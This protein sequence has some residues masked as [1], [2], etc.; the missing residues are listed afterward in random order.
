MNDLTVTR[1]LSED[2]KD[3]GKFTEAFMKS[4]GRHTAN[5]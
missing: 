5:S 4:A 2:L 3:V 1:R